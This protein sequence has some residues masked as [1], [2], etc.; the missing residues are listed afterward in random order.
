MPCYESVT[1]GT[2]LDPIMKAE[3]HGPSK[4][5]VVGATGREAYALAAPELVAFTSSADVSSPRGPC[6][7][8]RRTRAAMALAALHEDEVGQL[9][10]L[11]CPF[12]A[13]LHPAL[14]ATKLVQERPRAFGS[15]TVVMHGQSKPLPACSSL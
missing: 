7:P 11:S 10:E 1:C 9:Q 4:V 6:C 8:A 2:D 5:Y 14:L 15:K 3:L 12:L 13:K